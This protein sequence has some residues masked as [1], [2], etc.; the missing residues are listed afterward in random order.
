MSSDPVYVDDT[1]HESSSP[2]PLPSSPP[3][4][5][6]LQTV[7]VNSPPA[8]SPIP[9]RLVPALISNNLYAQ[10]ED[11]KT[12]YRR[13]NRYFGPASTWRAWTKE[14]RTT[15]LSLD[16]VRSQD[17][18]IHLFNAFHLKRKVQATAGGDSKRS[19]K[20]K[21]RAPSVLST[22]GYDDEDLPRR[23]EG[24]SGLAKSWTAWP[25][26]PDQ[27][28]REELLPPAVG[29]DEYRAKPDPRPSANLEECVIATAT[30]LARERWDARKWES[31]EEP[32]P[33]F[34][35]DMKVEHPEDAEMTTPEEDLPDEEGQDTEE[36]DDISAPAQAEDEP[37][38]FSQPFSF[39]DEAD[40]DM[41]PS[42]NTQD[43]SDAG[44]SEPERRPVPLA[45]DSKARQYFLPSARHILSK[46]DDLLLGLHK[47]R[48]AYAAKPPGR[49]RAS[50]LNLRRLRKVNLEDG[51]IHA[52]SQGR[53][54][55]RRLLT[56]RSRTSPTSLRRQVDGRVELR[57]L[58]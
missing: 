30:K 27:V 40:G 52:L 17:L 22:S 54:D 19:R 12:Y 48:S 37:M 21:E 8:V 53:G 29:E 36:E 2:D 25:L 35:R 26:P 16:R 46:L 6:T 55:A 23:T 43:Q 39:Y 42:R 56:A 24:R 20:G 32:A 4:I 38:F 10:G 15:A 9:K 31:E 5:T 28:P 47:A 1:D 11:G 14:E 34:K 33:V 45:D 44:I 58:G 18:S 41:P 57:T 7:G 3:Q 51:V 50:T 49:A 13:P